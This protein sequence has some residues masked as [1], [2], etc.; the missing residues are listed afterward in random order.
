MEKFWN[1]QLSK[2]VTH[3]GAK[4]VD[5]CVWNVNKLTEAQTKLEAGKL[6]NRAVQ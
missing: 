1:L 3:N 4:M 5:L 6:G 2:F